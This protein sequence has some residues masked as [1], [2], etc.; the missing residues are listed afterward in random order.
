MPAAVRSL[1]KASLAAVD[2]DNDQGG[3]AKSFLMTT[4][5]RSIMSALEGRLR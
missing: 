2:E 1:S 4:A 3:D 5:R